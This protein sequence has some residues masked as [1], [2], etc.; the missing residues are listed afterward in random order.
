[1]KREAG[2][3]V[4][5][6]FD[7]WYGEQVERYESGCRMMM[8]GA[9]AGLAGCFGLSAVALSGVGGSLEQAAFVA[10]ASLGAARFLQGL[11]RSNSD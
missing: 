7:T 2:Q 5:V 3:A 8:V 4:V 10:L 11:H 9:M 1:M 6:D